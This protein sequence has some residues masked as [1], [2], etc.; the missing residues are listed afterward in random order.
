MACIFTH[1]SFFLSTSNKYRKPHDNLNILR[2]SWVV[3]A[4]LGLTSISLSQTDSSYEARFDQAWRL[5]SERY[6]NIDADFWQTV[7][8]EFE[9]DALA[10]RNDREFYRVLEDMYDRIGDNHSVFVPPE[11]VA[12]IRE[13]F[14]DLPCLGIFS[15]SA[16][17]LQ[18][19]ELAS[20]ENYPSGVEAGLLSLDTAQQVGYIDVPNLATTGTARD[21]RRAVEQFSPT[22]NAFIVDLRGNPGGRLVEMMQA[23]GIFVNGFL[24]RTITSWTLPLPYPALG[25][26]ITDAPLV[27]LIDADVNSA[28]E[29]LA[30]G[31]Q[32]NGRATVIGQTS[33]GNVEAVLP[34]CLRDGSQAW[35]AT[36]VLA[37]LQGATWEGMGVVPDVSTNPDDALDA[38]LK[39]LAETL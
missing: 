20:L 11:R 26:A 4:L 8:D 18:T 39:Y 15:W 29:G 33:A 30:G 13:D 6:W 35:I 32:A 2:L 10:A 28:A 19:N 22:A 23:A 12:E 25:L 34:F 27:M 5:V 21:M 38:A 14:G 1:L 16:V 9:A 24:W 7:R 3:L 36:G 37:P 31:L 17:G